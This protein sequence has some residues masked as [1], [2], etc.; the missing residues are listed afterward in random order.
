MIERGFVGLQRGL[1]KNI[2]LSI[3][4]FSWDEV[5]RVRDAFHEIASKYVKEYKLD[6]NVP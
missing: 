4:G 1:T 3:Y 5:R 6:Y 2:K